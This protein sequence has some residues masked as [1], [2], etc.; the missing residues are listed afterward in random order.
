MQNIDYSR[1]IKNS[2]HVQS[3]GENP[4][5]THS[6][7]QAGRP[8]SGRG[9]T[10]EQLDLQRH[11]RTRVFLLSGFMVVFFLGTVAGFQIHRWQH[12]ED[13]IV[14]YPDE[15]LSTEKKDG[16]AS[17]EA[18]ASADLSDDDLSSRE[19]SFANRGDSEPGNGVQEQTGIFMI[20][21]GNLPA[22]TAEKLSSRLNNLDS[23]AQ[24]KPLK[25]P[26][27]EEDVPGRYLSFRTPSEKDPRK[28]NVVVGCFADEESVREVLSQIRSSGVPGSAKARIYQ[29]Q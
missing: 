13:S 7:L 10:Q 5:A 4:R 27:F 12:I 18:M 6:P 29:A 23:I 25:C 17:P 9:E 20:K 15:K 1:R 14:K 3:H 2:S 24:L 19:Q 11:N 21:I 16:N 28:Q 8:D 26:D 22:A